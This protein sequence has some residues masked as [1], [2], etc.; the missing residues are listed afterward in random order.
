MSPR[1]ALLCRGLLG[2]VVLLPLFWPNAARCATP[3]QVDEAIEKGKK[4]LYS[5]QKPGGHWEPDDK[6][7]GI[8]HVKGKDWGKMQG[9]SWGG[10][11]ALATYA[12]L[13]SGENP[14][15]PKIQE[16]VAFLE[17][18]EIISIYGL[19]IRCQIWLLLPPSAKTRAMANH[20]ARLILEGVIKD[21]KKHPEYNGF[22]EYG[23]GHGEDPKKG[24]RHLDHSISQYGI[25]GLWAASK[26]GVEVD[27][28]DWKMFENA[29]K[30][31]Q[32]PDGGWQYDGYPA[33]A[34]P[35]KKETASMTAA[36]IATLFIT[37][38]FLHSDDGVNCG[39]NITN[40]AIEKGLKWMT[41]NFSTVGRNVYT[42]Y[43]LERIGVASGNKYFGT[44]D[45]YAEGADRLVKAQKKDGSWPGGGVKEGDMPVVN[46]AF[47]LLF[48]SRGRAPVMMNK[49]QYDVIANGKSVEA[50]WNQRPR[51]VAN[52]VH[53]T[54]E[55][56]ERDLNWQIVNLKVP[57]DELHDA[58]ILY[59]SGDQ[60]LKFTDEEMAKLKQFVEG[61]GMI[62]GT[63]DCGMAK[64]QFSQSFEQLGTKLLNRPFRDLPPNHIIFTNEAYRASGWK[65]PP[66]VRGI[67][68]GVR[69]Q[70]ILVSDADVGR[71]WQTRAEKT[72]EELYQFGADLFLYSVD[73]KSLRNKGETFVVRLNP[74]IK[75]EKT[76]K[77][78][79]LV[80]GDNWNPEPGGWRRMAAIL[81]NKDKAD[82]TVEP[83]DLAKQT[84]SGFKLAHL[85]G[86]GHFKLTDVQR[87]RLAE[88]V[89][90]GGTLVLDAAGGSGEFA[91]SAEAELRA[92]FPDAAAKALTDPLDIE[93]PI[94]ELPDAKIESVT[95][96]EMYKTK[97]VG[98]LKT[99]RLYGIDRSG[100]I[101]VFYSRED[102]TAGMVGEPVDGIAGYTP[103]SAT[104][105][106]RNIVLYSAFGVRPGQPKPASI[107]EATNAVGK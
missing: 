53:W 24:P 91:D 68:N 76:A 36:G 28:A 26:C 7:V 60:D 33:K 45:W 85:T 22:W 2:C 79:Q 38:E 101:G 82:I 32:F 11:S 1:C 78:A 93:S 97:V 96:R 70:M 80:V 56:M 9:D 87:R 74:K 107:T 92:L 13:A 50:D 75:A 95:Y 3:E 64:P 99:P 42:L 62:F 104:A 65:S 98:K 72:H 48:L 44:I 15:E 23:N 39:G 46:T 12:L 34:D 54:G 31:H 41:E 58:P 66:K 10:F 81:H 59:I 100:R 8:G 29:W 89:M 47:A 43:G 52:I 94:F 4:F 49:L 51:D 71:A 55:Q 6:R 14:Q 16:A 88:F 40:P 86:T 102:L 63:A 25:L 5:Q 90:H 27:L 18:A 37:E 84:L 105:I 20:D 35:K 103:E 21:D 77:I 17:K 67:S 69:E 30:S 106:M 19:G 61:G 83:I 57:V 73:K